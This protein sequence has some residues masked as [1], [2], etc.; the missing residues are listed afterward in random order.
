[1]HRTALILAV[2]IMLVPTGSIFARTWHVPD[3]APTIQAGID[4]AAAGDTVMVECNTYY[5]SNIQFWKSGIVLTSETGQPDCVTIDPNQF[6]RA[7]FISTVDS[8]TV[9]NGLTLTNGWQTSGGALVTNNSSVKIMNCILSGN[10]ASN[11]GGAIQ[12]NAATP[13]FTN[14]LIAGNSAGNRGGGLASWTST[15]VFRNCTFS[16]NSAADGGHVFSDAGVNSPILSNTILAFSGAG[17]AVHCAGSNQLTI[18]H[19]CIFGN[20]G[21]DSLCGNYSQNLFTDPG[22]CGAGNPA[23]PYSVHESSPCAPSFNP[24]G[25]WIGAYESGCPSPAEPVGWGNVKKMFE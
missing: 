22:F 8:N 15:P 1:M 25:E 18:T 19:C 21:G 11:S 4:S 23:Q 5:E 14:C 9:V 13:T 24:W 6:H 10:T 7:L 2:T 3:D 16:S 12:M 17:G 20:A